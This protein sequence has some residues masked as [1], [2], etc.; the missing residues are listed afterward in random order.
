VSNRGAPTLDIGFAT[1]IGGRRRNEDH[2]GWVSPTATQAV[3]H[4]TVIALADGVGGGK[5]GR[6]AA[7]TAVRGFLDGYLSLSPQIGVQK[8]AASVLQSLNDWLHMVG[9]RDPAL[10]GLACTFT[11]LVVRGRTAHVFHVG[12]S[13][14]YHFCDGRLDRLTRDHGLDRPGQE[15]VLCRALGFEPGV[16]VDYARHPLQVHDRLLLCSDGVHGVLADPVLAEV[17]AG[18]ESPQRTARALV[19][20]A[21]AAGGRDNATAVVV[22]VLSL[23]AVA[24]DGIA[25]TLAGLPIPPVPVTGDLVDGFRI[26]RCLGAAR[27]TVLYQAI[28][29]TDGSSVVLKFPRPRIASERGAVSAFLRE[30]WVSAA[31]SSPYL[32]RALTL[33]AGRQSRLYALLPFYEGETLAQRVARQ[34]RLGLAEGRRIGIALC[35]ALSALHRARIIHRDVK[36]DNVL[37]GPDGSVRLLDFGVVR[38]PGIEEAAPTVVPGTASVM[39]PEMFD[40]EAG[41][42]RT[43]LYALGATLFFAFTGSYPYGEIEAFSRPRF[44]RPRSMAK[45][46]PDLPSWVGFAIAKTVSVRPEERFADAI[47][48]LQALESGPQSQPAGPP[49]HRPLYR[50]NP[51]AVW[52]SVAFGLAIALLWLLARH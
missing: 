47:E 51:V 19:S 30:A 12:D 13:R 44:S 20:A 38:L 25:E 7:E 49:P 6:E 9:R 4:G 37:L 42:E 52:Q 16:R 26:G 2:A 11:G 41:D 36:P 28:D 14:L 43:D 29:E 8:A 15:H 32:G 3:R 39:A 40:G 33:T 31:V 18:R 48:L 10:A 34:P 46:R 45:E 27:Q 35:R 1:E 22:D 21:L 23:P 24:W 5:G 50:R 17:L